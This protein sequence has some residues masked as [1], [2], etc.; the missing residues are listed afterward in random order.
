MTTDPKERIKHC[1]E[2]IS[3]RCFKARDYFKPNDPNYE[4][5]LPDMIAR[6]E[7]FAKEIIEMA[8]RLE[9]KEKT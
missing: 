5:E 4:F 3:R 8:D 7:G 9:K 6:I 1:A 2:Q